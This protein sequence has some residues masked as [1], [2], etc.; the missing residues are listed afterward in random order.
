MKKLMMT[1]TV[2][3]SLLLTLGVAQA[4]DMQAAA[5][6][7]N[8]KGVGVSL[9]TPDG[10]VPLADGWITVTPKWFVSNSSDSNLTFKTE[11]GETYLFTVVANQLS[12]ASCVASGKTV[13]LYVESNYISRTGCVA[14]N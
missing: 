9:D 13:L 4:I 7:A 10:T 3:A 12:M 6:L 8:S 2:L 1:L 5:D 11:S 14:A